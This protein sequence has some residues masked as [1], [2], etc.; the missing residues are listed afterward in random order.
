[1]ITNLSR[2]FYYQVMAVPMRLNNWRYRWLSAPTSGLKVHLG[3]GQ[4][5][6]LP[7]WIN[8]DGNIV[9]AKP[10]LWINLDDPLPFRSNS[11][12]IFYS[13]HV[14]EHFTENSLS[15][16]LKEMY[17]CLEPGAGLRIGVPHAG[18]AFR[19][20]AQ[21]REDWFSSNFPRNRKSIGGRC[22][23]FLLCAN[24]HLSLFDYSYFEE[25]LVPIGYVDLKECLPCRESALVGPDVLSF[26]SESDFE[27]PHTLVVEAWKPAERADKQRDHSVA[28]ANH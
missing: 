19:M 14:L 23:N 3:C 6:Y 4:K 10:D 2:R 21:G 18:N 20:Y 9:T 22:D 24:E 13:N 7:G 11:V 8:V 5:H 16:L 25:L 17:R 27:V 1:M 28:S 12:R 26:E 15:Q